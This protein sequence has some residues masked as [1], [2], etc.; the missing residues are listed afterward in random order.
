MELHSLV[1]AEHAL[2]QHNHWISA[3][4][5]NHKSVLRFL[6]CILLLYYISL[7]SFRTR[8]GGTNPSGCDQPE[9][10]EDVIF[11]YKTSTT[12]SYTQIYKL[13]YNGERIEFLDFGLQICLE[14]VL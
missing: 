11:E 13:A 10:G 8:L 14:H 2:S 5:R 9:S 7:I 12:T 1:K 6:R 3:V 4:H